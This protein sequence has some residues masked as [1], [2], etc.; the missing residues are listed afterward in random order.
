MK[1]NGLGN[2]FLRHLALAAP[3]GI[4][5]LAVLFIAAMGFKQQTKET[6]QYAARVISYG[7]LNAAE[8]YHVMS[9]IKKNALEIIEF[10]ALKAK[11][12]MKDLLKDPQVKNDLRE[13][14]KNS[15]TDHN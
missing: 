5:S 11:N 14:F 7:T 13:I 10:T 8:D 15:K 12:E 9:S 1:E 3:W 2:L 6:V 4:I